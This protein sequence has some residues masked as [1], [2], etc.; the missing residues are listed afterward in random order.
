MWTNYSNVIGFAYALPYCAERPAWDSTVDI[1]FYFHKDVKGL[2]V[3]GELL[4]ALLDRMG[5][6]KNEDGIR[7]VLAGVA[8]NSFKGEG[9][10]DSATFYTKQGFMERRT[11]KA[12]GRKFGE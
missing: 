1:S 9:Q 10:K 7:E 11:L 5:K 2:G 12:V 3:G 8:R 6:K 4:N